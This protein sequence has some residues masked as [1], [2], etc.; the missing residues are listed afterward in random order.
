MAKKHVLSS[1]LAYV[2][3]L[4]I[5][6]IG[7]VFMEKADFG[8]SMVVAPAYVLH[9]VISPVLPFFTFGTA[10]YVFQGVLLLM[11]V[12]VLR[13]FRVSYLLS[14]ATAFIYGMMLDGL[15][16]L[17]QALPVTLALRFVYYIVGIVLCALGVT[18]LLR[19]YITPE[20][21]ELFV[22]EAA[23]KT[24]KPTRVVKTVYDVCSCLLAVVLSFACFGFGV[25]RGVKWGTVACAL[26]N[27]MLIG[28]W[29]KLL[30]KRFTLTDSLPW[31]PFFAGNQK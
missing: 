23:E 19:T 27:G 5:L 26:V 17:G 12:P 15:L 9:L 1:E 13:R 21:Y 16:A 25:F 14:F 4:V 2:L 8:M 22:R 10:E 3:G 28:M 24:G 20:A 31:R 29:D 7:T 30:L 11:M 18:F 6:G